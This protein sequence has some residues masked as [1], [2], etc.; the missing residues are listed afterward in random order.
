[1]KKFKP[2]EIGYYGKPITALTRDELLKAFVELVEVLSEFSK[3]NK[4][5]E[6]YLF[7]DNQR[8]DNK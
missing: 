8:L 5:L 2:E 6:K 1:V 7:I 3:E 4:N